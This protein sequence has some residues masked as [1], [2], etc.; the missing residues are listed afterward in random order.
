VARDGAN[1]DAAQAICQS[2]VSRR[3]IA[4]RET[5]A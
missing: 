2:R 1:F 4:D 5:S 3:E